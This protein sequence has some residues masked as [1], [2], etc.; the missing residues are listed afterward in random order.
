ML[1]ITFILVM[2]I[3]AALMESSDIAKKHPWRSLGLGLVIALCGIA[4]IVVLAVT[5]IGL[6]LAGILLAIFLVTTYLAKIYAGVFIGRLLI[7]PKKMTKGKLF[8][9]TALGIFIIKI[10]ELVPL[11][12]WLI[13]MLTVI[14]GFGA[15]WTHKKILYEKL[16]LQKL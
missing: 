13:A 7:N 9:I 5:L 14:L 16:N 4:S 6:A 11:V 10:V 8:G 2:F 15:L 3:P 12:G 1:V